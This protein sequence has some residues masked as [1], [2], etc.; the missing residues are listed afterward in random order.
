M[1]LTLFCRTLVNIFYSNL[2][3]FFGF[4][5]KVVVVVGGGGGVVGGGGG[6]GSKITPT[7][8]NLLGLC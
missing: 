4:R 1:V 7:I 2:G 5:F 8:Y 3:G 6:G